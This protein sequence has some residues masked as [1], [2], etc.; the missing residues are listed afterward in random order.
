MFLLPRTLLFLS[1]FKRST[2]G[3]TAIEFSLVAVPFFFLLYA[4]IDVSL[5]FFAS[6]TLENG[7][8]S[9]ARQIRTGKVQSTNMTEAQFRTLVCNEISMFLA[10][11][12]RLGVDVRKY[13]GFNDAEFEPALDE[14][15][16]LSGDMQYDP[17][18]A[19]DVVVVRAFYTWPMLTPAI[20]PLFTNMAG[21]HRLL[22]ASIAFRN[23]PFG[24]ILAN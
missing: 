2:S 8:V 1:R 12:A 20:G 16:N 5:I 14:N 13:A 10:C 19:G 24:S 11:D 23:E 6:T 7:V 4:I 15:G 17:G 21:N 22:E 18:T 9:A 3:V